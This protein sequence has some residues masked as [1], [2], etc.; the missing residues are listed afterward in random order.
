MSSATLKVAGLALSAAT[1]A[2]ITTTYAGPA[3]AAPPPGLAAAGGQ[4]C[5]AL[6]GRTFAGATIEKVDFIASGTT[7]NAIVPKT[8]TD[9]CQVHA[10][11]SP[12]AGSEIKFD[13]WLPSGWN[14]K[15]LGTGGGGF[16]GGLSSAAFGLV[17]PVNKGYVALATDAGHDVSASPVWALNNP[18]KIVDFGYRANH[19]GAVAAKAIIAF[20][21]GA[22]AKRAYFQGCSNGGR[23]A[24]MLAQRYP[25]DYDG[26]VAGAPANDWTGLFAAFMHDDQVIGSAPGVNAKLKLVH[27]AAIQKCDALDGAKDGLISNPSQCRFDPVILQCK[28][29][30]GSTCLSKSEVTAVRAIYQGTRAADGRLIMPGFSPGSEYQWSS[31]FSTPKG[32]ASGMGPDFY[33]YMVF[34]EPTWERSQFVLARDYPETKRRLS[35]VLD[36]TNPD[37]RPFVRHGG[38]LLMYHGWDDAAIPPGNSVRYYKA[39]RH[40][41]GPKA[42]NARLFMVPGMAHCAG[43]NGP[44]FFDAVGALDRWVEGGKAPERLTVAKYDSFVRAL[45]G[46]PAKVLSTRPICAWPKTSHYAGSGSV[47]D[48]ASFVCR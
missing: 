31:W 41:L 23:D 15:M 47:D 14:G 38:K 28:A 44:G 32:A 22:S 11:I 45:A 26:I 16:N 40:A 35:S 19:V 25:N 46:A 21:Y 5:A 24:L 12:V 36:A 29:G 8:Q 7:I 42:G 18:E 48:A 37:L 30:D 34:G 3:P 39:V 9:I 6:A 10:R 2:A 43:G 33:R 17:A 1:A 13:V 27:D 4:S 20:Y